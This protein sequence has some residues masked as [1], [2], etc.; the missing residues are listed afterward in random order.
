MVTRKEEFR[1]YHSNL[2]A[3]L[4]F[5]FLMSCNNECS[6][7][8]KKP[9]VGKTDTTMVDIVDSAQPISLDYDTIQWREVL[10][11]DSTIFLD[12]RYASENNFTKQQ[13]YD[14]PR[15]FLR[16][17]VY[18]K[19][20]RFQSHMLEKHGYG[21]LLFDCYRPRPYQQKLWDIVPDERFVGNPAKGSMHNRGMAVDI[22]LVDENGKILD[23]GSD[24]DHFGSASF[25]S[26]KDISSE[27]IANRLLLKNGIAQ[28][29][30]MPITSEWW[31]Y[32]YRQNISPLTEWVWPCNTK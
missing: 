3:V 10:P 7:P 13:I 11:N 30:F 2:M 4:L 5:S 16:P 14:C 29:G 25:H 32:S 28:F 18:D 8:T 23:M 26:A 21:I 17:I 1:Y 12:I 6:Q 22:T 20:V 24:F 27:A 9:T 19:L 15:C 31:H